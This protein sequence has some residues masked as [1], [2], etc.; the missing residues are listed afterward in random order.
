ME[1]NC[2]I[3]CVGGCVCANIHVCTRLSDMNACK[4]IAIHLINN[5]SMNIM[6]VC[7]QFIFQYECERK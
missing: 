3:N 5:L 7:Y 1:L 4:K 6:A 2:K